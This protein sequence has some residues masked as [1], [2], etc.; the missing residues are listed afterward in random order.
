MK[1]KTIAISAC[2]AFAVASPAL[3]QDEGPWRVGETYVVRH[4][5]LDLA[6]PTGR[7][8]LLAAIE[9]AA[10]RVCAPYATRGGRKA[11][12]E[13]AVERALDR[14]PQVRTVIATARLERGDTRL[15]LR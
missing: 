6:T 10:N 5:A 13:Q 4:Q 7:A 12:R 9:G 3:A 15:A 11:C 1:F 2:L 8:R 14:T